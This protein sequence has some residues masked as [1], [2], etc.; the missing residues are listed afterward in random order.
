MNKSSTIQFKLKVEKCPELPRVTVIVLRKIYWEILYFP[1]NLESNIKI[2]KF[3]DLILEFEA[4]LKIALNFIHFWPN[5]F[6][7]KNKM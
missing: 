1:E 6:Y 2:F 5:F 3:S 7:Q 4:L